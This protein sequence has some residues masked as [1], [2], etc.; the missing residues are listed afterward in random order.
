MCARDEN[1]KAF[2]DIDS[3][4]Y[5]FRRLLHDIRT[6]KGF[7]KFNDKKAPIQMSKRIFG[8]FFLC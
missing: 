6:F 4:Q 1:S 7:F 8:V 2:V 3:N 5:E